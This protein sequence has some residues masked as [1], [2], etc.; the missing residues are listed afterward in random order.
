MN[1][2]GSFNS[3]IDTLL[4]GSSTLV[5]QLGGTAIYY[6]DAPDNKDLP[7]V[8]W[9]W[10][11]LMDENQTPSRMF[12]AIINVRVFSASKTQAGTIDGT[13]DELLN[14]HT[15]SVSGNTNF[16]TARIDAFGDVDK[17]PNGVKTYIAGGLYR[18]RT[19][20]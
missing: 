4:T 20:Q 7:Y 14:G 17:E 10:Q 6:I 5:S 12:N 18:I 1:V 16:F 2:L 15:V 9:N 11:S 19:G 8:V 3:A 13:I